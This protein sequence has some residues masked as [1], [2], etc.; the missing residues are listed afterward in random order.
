MSGPEDY[1]KGE[2][3]KPVALEH[4]Q[5]DAD[6]RRYSPSTARNRDVILEAFRA[7]VGRGGHVLEIAFGHG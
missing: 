6:G 7:L 3:G 5:A 4:R 2:D 1:R